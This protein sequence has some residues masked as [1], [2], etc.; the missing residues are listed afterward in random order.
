M[1]TY[2]EIRTITRRNV[3]RVPNQA[4]AFAR[5]RDRAN[6]VPAGGP[7]HLYARHGADIRPVA[8]RLGE[9]DDTHTEITALDALDEHAQILLKDTP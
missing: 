2:V 7:R 3:M 9:A 5:G 8:V 6:G 1:T 4:L